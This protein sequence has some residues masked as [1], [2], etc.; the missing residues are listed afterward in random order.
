ML[1]AVLIL[2]AL[3][4][5]YRRRGGNPERAQHRFLICRPGMGTTGVAVHPVDS[6]PWKS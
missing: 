2:R 6:L 3:T 4:K 5:S 1:G